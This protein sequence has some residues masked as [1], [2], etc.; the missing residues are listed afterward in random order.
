MTFSILFTVCLIFG[1]DNRSAVSLDI[2]DSFIDSSMAGETISLD[3]LEEVQETR[4][5]KK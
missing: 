1:C 3:Q 5:I 4:E 2:G